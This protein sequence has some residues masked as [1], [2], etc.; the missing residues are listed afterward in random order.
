MT[1][2]RSRLTSSA[3]AFLRDGRDVVIV[4]HPASEAAA[5]RQHVISEAI[6][7]A[8]RTWNESGDEE[9]PIVRCRPFG[10]GA[11]EVDRTMPE[12]MR[13]VII[14][15][16]SACFERGGARESAVRSVIA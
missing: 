5:L 7:A 1:P 9:S 11:V 10:C 4:A 12:P 3:L 13:P 2:F 16:L 6:K 14:Y 15:D 8:I